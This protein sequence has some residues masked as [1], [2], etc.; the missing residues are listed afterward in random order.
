MFSGK[1]F[2]N[3][4]FEMCMNLFLFSSLIHELFIYLFLKKFNAWRQKSNHLF[5]FLGL[6]ACQM[7]HLLQFSEM[8]Q[9]LAAHVEYSVFFFVN[10]ISYNYLL[11]FI[12]PK[13]VLSFWKRSNFLLIIFVFKRKNSTTNK[14]MIKKTFSPCFYPPRDTDL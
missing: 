2:F 3:R 4:N 14:N 1:I 10:F 11:I 12:C 8:A 5:S 13:C 6:K 7:W 9:T